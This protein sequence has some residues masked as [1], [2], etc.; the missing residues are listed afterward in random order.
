MAFII[1]LML[2][3]ISLMLAE[4][5]VASGIGVAGILGLLSLAASCCYAF[6]EFGSLVGTAVTVF[7]VAA[8]VVLTIFIVRSRIRKKLSGSRGGRKKGIFTDDSVSVGDRGV[9]VSELS[10]DG[11]AIL[12]SETVPV[13]ALEG[14]I[15]RGADVEVVLIEDGRIY[16]K[17]A[18]D[19]F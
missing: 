6:S 2:V 4:I 17:P 7:D 8:A 11:T 16:V 18:N 13:T 19:D 10:P 15:D 14:K 9:S 3:G 12:G 5:L 1:I